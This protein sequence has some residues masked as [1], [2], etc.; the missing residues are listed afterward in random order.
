MHN[1]Y[2]F[3]VCMF[4]FLV[5]RRIPCQNR[6]CILIINHLQVTVTDCW[7]MYEWEMHQL[8]KLKN[9]AKSHFCV[10]LVCIVRMLVC[11]GAFVCVCV[12]VC[13]RVCYAFRIVS[14]DKVFALY[15]YLIINVTC[16]WTNSPSQFSTETNSHK[17]KPYG[18]P[19]KAMTVV[20]SSRTT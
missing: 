10:H 16:I 11:A 20:P 19:V 13:V 17:T 4:Q 1:F 6:T 8:S 18:W 14:R 12:C 3:G 9:S 7:V 5:S 15:K 2:A